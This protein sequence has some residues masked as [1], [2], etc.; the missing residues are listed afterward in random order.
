MDVPQPKQEHLLALKVSEVLEHVD[1][2]YTSMD[3]VL[4]YRAWQRDSALLQKIAEESLK[5]F[6]VR[7]L[8]SFIPWFPNDLCKLPL[9]PKR[10]PPVISVEEAE[11]L[12]QHYATL[13][14]PCGSP[15]Y[16]CTEGLKEFHP[17]IKAGQCLQAE[18]GKFELSSL[19]KQLAT[20]KQNIR[21]SW[22]AS[23]SNAKLKDKI[24]PLSRELQS[25]LEKLKL[26]VFYRAQWIIEPSTLSNQTLEDIWTKLN[27]MIKH[28]E[29]PSCNSTF[30]RSKE[31]ILI[32]CDILYC[33]YIANYL[34][35]KLNLRGKMN[36]FVHKYGII[37]S[38]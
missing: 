14:T 19:E 2:Y 4:H 5:E 26:H 3:V 21:R 30:Q 31:Q 27:R 38:L 16:D 1:S 35:E 9:K 28:N 29:L 20:G 17:D 24:L 32:F 33:E 11:Q 13:E 22:S 23:A 12:K 34:K 18:H 10:E 36:L 6:P 7:Q 15:C 25:T 37:H 8:P